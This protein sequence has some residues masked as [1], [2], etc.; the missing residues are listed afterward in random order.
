MNLIV[1]IP[2]AKPLLS[3]EIVEAMPPLGM[4]EDTAIVKYIN[5]NP[6]G[7]GEWWAAEM[8]VIVPGK[9]EVL[10]LA[11]YCQKQ[12]IGAR[13]L[14][15]RMLADEVQILCF[16]AVALRD[17]GLGFFLLNDLAAFRGLWGIAIERDTDYTPMTLDEIR[18]E[19]MNR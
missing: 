12:R 7:L 16:G 6:L 2:P 5:P 15:R 1:N 11:D 14:E 3:Q 4:A 18:T 19:V 17:A 8:G 13:T 10:S 9:R